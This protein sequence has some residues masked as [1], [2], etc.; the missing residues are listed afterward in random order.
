M[1]CEDSDGVG[2][3]GAGDLLEVEAGTDDAEVFLRV[4]FGRLK[5]WEVGVRSDWQFARERIGGCFAVFCGESFDCVELIEFEDAAGAVVSD[6]HGE[7]KAR[8]FKRNKT[9]AFGVDGKPFLKAAH[10]PQACFFGAVGAET[11]VYVGADNDLFEFA[12]ESEH[13]AVHVGFARKFFE[14]HVVGGVAEEEFFEACFRAYR[15]S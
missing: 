9:G 7:E 5:F 8:F 4:D 11:V 12:V 2:T 6:V 1:S 3:V 10:E 15:G 13:F 14:A